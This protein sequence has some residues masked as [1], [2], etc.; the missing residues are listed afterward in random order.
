MKLQLSTLLPFL[1]A[2]TALAKHTPVILPK[3]MCTVIGARRCVR[4]GAF[5]N[6]R[7]V[8]RDCDYKGDDRVFEICPGGC[9]MEPYGFVRC[10]SPETQTTTNFHHNGINDEWGH[11]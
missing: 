6:R 9:A 11:D 10:V 4:Q 1:A 5:E 7:W 8:I 3:E 2:S